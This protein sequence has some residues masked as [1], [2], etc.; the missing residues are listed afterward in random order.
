MV[1]QVNKKEGWQQRHTGYMRLRLVWLSRGAVWYGMVP[2]RLRLTA[3]GAPSQISTVLLGVDTAGTPGQAYFY[4]YF[5]LVG[6]SAPYVWYGYGMV[7]VCEGAPVAVSG[8]VL[9]DRYDLACFII[10]WVWYG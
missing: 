4:F 8:W 7:E 2:S 9:T 3:T 10:F 6:S 5:I 1:T